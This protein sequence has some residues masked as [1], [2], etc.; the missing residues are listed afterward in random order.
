MTVV[1][2][3]ATLIVWAFMVHAGLDGSP[4]GRQRQN[5]AACLLLAVWTFY[6][7]GASLFMR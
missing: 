2:L 3:A 4:R 6:V 5:D 1:M 7:L